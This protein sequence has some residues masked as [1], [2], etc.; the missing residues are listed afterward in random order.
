M[1]NPNHKSSFKK[2]QKWK[3]IEILLDPN[4]KPQKFFKKKSR[5]GETNKCWVNWIHWILFY[6]KYLGFENCIFNKLELLNASKPIDFF[7]CIFFNVCNIINKISFQCSA[8]NES[9]VMITVAKYLN[10]FVIDL[11]LLRNLRTDFSIF[12]GFCLTVTNI[13]TKNEV[14]LN[15]SRKCACSI[16]SRAFFKLFNL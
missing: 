13:S 14:G 9:V 3:K 5:N 2:I 8:K 16:H 1:K 4:S 10:N 6:F 12:S 7:I 15:L 11:N